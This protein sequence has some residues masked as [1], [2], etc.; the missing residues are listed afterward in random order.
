MYCGVRFNTLDEKY[1]DQ[2]LVL[3]LIQPLLDHSL[4][5]CGNDQLGNDYLLKHIAFILQVRFCIGRVFK[6]SLI[7]SFI[8][9]FIVV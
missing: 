6:Y 1:A 9:S 3:S 2:Q 4:T 8:L 5:L 7:L